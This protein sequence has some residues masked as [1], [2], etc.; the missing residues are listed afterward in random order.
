MEVWRGVSSKSV[1]FVTANAFLYVSFNASQHCRSKGNATKRILLH[2]VALQFY[3]CLFNSSKILFMMWVQPWCTICLAGSLPPNPPRESPL[4]SWS[5]L[6]CYPT[7]KLLINSEL[8]GERNQEKKD[9]EWLCSF[10]C[11]HLFTAQIPVLTVPKVTCCVQRCCGRETQH[12]KLGE[13]VQWSNNRNSGPV[14]EKGWKP[15]Y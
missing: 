9:S 2:S 8:M 4:L 14:L 1:S 6:V 10:V 13:S 15:L 12:P 11:L 3:F 5:P 7:P